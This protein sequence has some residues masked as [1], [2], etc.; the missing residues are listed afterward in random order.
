MSIFPRQV[1]K[2]D[3]SAGDE[4]HRRAEQIA[5]ERVAWSKG[6]VVGV[7]TCAFVL[8]LVWTIVQKQNAPF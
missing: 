1:P 3:P 7:L 2:D 4:A 8:G 6:F 5:T